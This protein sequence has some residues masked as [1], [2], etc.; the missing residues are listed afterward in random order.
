[1]I[2]IK[3]LLVIIAMVLL[4]GC[5]AANNPLPPEEDLGTASTGPYIVFAGQPDVN[6]GEDTN[7]YKVEFRVVDLNS[8]FSEYEGTPAVDL[9]LKIGDDTYQRVINMTEQPGGIA[10]PLSAATKFELRDFECGETVSARAELLTPGFEQGSPLAD[11]KV[12][13]RYV[14]NVDDVQTYQGTLSCAEGNTP[15]EADFSIPESAEAG[16][17]IFIDS[18]SVDVDSGDN[19][20]NSL[21]HEWRIDGELQ[22]LDRNTTQRFT[23]AFNETGVHTVSLRVS[24]PEGASDI[25]LKTIEV[26]PR[27]EENEEVVADFTYQPRNPR[28]GQLVSLDASD[29]KG[30]SKIDSYT[31]YLDQ[32]QTPLAES[33][34]PIAATAF[35]EPGTHLVSLQVMTSE[36]VDVVRKQIRVSSSRYTR[37]GEPIDQPGE[38]VERIER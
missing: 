2:H 19:T 27:S 12:V 30:I 3:S 5:T 29:S 18:S 32:E 35:D 6:R 28:V 20:G 11:V 17:S 1:M 36:G 14:D 25:V 26:T 9:S 4:V 33:E 8:D 13:S 22:Q 37:P 15:P 24:D 21:I 23:H 10:N 38:P 16:E 7:T 34:D 31:W